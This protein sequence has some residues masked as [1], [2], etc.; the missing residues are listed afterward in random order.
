MELGALSNFN[1]LIK[2][3][4]I[5]KLL[6]STEWTGGNLCLAPI[7]LPSDSEQSPFESYRF[8]NFLCIYGEWYRFKAT[9]R[10]DLIIIFKRSLNYFP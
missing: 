2:I 8:T 7:I 4:H 9:M 6:K 10:S 3:G 1:S 5:K